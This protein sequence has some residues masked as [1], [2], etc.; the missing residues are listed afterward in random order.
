M[1]FRSLVAAAALLSTVSFA[2]VASA[3][4]VTVPPGGPNQPPVSAPGGPNPGYPTGNTPAAGRRGQGK[5]T[6]NIGREAKR[7]NKIIGLLQRD[8]RDYGGHRA[9]AIDMLRQA[10]AELQQ[11]VDW[12]RAHTGQ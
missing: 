2:G 7:L 12:D 8:E 5:A 4:T 1:T 3:Q 9:R 11:A 6:Y 10:Q